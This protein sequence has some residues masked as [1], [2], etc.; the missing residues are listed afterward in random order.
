MVCPG[1]LFILVISVIIID[2]AGVDVHVG[3]GHHGRDGVHGVG[4]AAQRRRVATGGIIS[5]D[6]ISLGFDYGR[7]LCVREY[8]WSAAKPMRSLR[9]MP[10][11]LQ[12][13]CDTPV[14]RADGRG[15]VAVDDGRRGVRVG[16]AYH[17]MT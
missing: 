5:A 14:G 8:P 13:H 11:L 10:S 3:L 17:S 9:A 15:R 7:F 2:L 16:G 12:S 6:D 1:R 4:R